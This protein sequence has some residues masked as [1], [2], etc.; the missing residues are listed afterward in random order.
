MPHDGDLRRSR[1]ERWILCCMVN[2][3]L[4]A[5][6]V[7]SSTLMC[8]TPVE[9][10]PFLQYRLLAVA[11]STRWTAGRG[12]VFYTAPMQTLPQRSGEESAVQLSGITPLVQENDI[13]VHQLAY[14]GQWDM[15]AIGVGDFG[16]NGPDFNCD[17]DIHPNGYNS[18]DLLQPAPGPGPLRFFQ[19]TL[20]DPI[21]G[22]V[23]WND[24]GLSLWDASGTAAVGVQTESPPGWF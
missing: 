4:Q 5:L 11:M 17:Q 20:V 7:L 21:Y 14:T 1:A 23:D 19:Q 24:A 18:V 22:S 10:S 6:H 2:L 9:V 3:V 12:R 15:N 16:V 13:S 8:A